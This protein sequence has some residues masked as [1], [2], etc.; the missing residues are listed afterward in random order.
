[1][2]TN[3]TGKNPKYGVW[4]WQNWEGQARNTRGSF[5]KLDAKKGELLEW[6]LK[7]V[8]VFL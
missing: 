8:L 1:M 2:P 4:V 7:D 6:F 5:E 3:S